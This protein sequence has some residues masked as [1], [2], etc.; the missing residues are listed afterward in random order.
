VAALPLTTGKSLL[1]GDFHPPGDENEE[2][3]EVSW[4]VLKK[5]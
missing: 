1:R 2:E 4:Q 5:E 3:M